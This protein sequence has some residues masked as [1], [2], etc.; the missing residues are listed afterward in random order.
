MN[1]DDAFQAYSLEASHRDKLPIEL[2]CKQVLYAIENNSTTLVI[3]ETGS[4]KSTKLPELLLKTNLYTS[5]S[6]AT[7][8]IAMTLP[9]RISVMN[10]SER[11]ASNLGE[12]VGGRVG[13]SV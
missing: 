11:I 10:I 7:K 9:K 2:K 3:G 12:R 4:G 13:I 1:A 6:A 8:K 5:G